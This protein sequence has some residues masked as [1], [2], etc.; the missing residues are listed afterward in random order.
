VQNEWGYFKV[1]VNRAAREP[2]PFRDVLQRRL[3]DP[4]LGE[5]PLRRVENLVARLLR[6]LSGSFHLSLRR[7]MAD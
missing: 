3:G 4:M 5:D 2:G 6:L 1:S 7:C